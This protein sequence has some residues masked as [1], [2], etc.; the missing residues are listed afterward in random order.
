MNKNNRV[1]L[2][3]MAALSVGIILC[4][5]GFQPVGAKE[6]KAKS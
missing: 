4:L 3:T 5:S 1:A 2:F 6:K